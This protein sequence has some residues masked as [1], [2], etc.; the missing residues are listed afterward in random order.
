MLDEAYYEYAQSNDEY[1]NG[2]EILR[3]R[4]NTI[5]LRTFA[6]VAGLAGLRVGYAFSSEEIIT[7]M[8]KTTGVFNVN[9]IAQVAATASIDDEEHINKT[10]DLNN[11]SLNYMVEY[12]KRKGLEYVPTSTNFI[13]VN[14]GMD[15]KIAFVELQKKGMI[16][17]P[18][19][20]W[21]YDTWARISSGDME[22]TIK[23]IKVLDEVIG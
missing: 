14:I 18:G 17:R 2:L 23:F 9:R 1:P 3:N 20:I 15:S 11:K 10:V 7:E 13:F 16:M 8:N 12:F 21:G 4:K 19:F 6:K 22:S 5:V